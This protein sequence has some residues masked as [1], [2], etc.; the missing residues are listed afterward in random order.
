DETN[1]V[2]EDA[3]LTVT[4]GS[5]DVLHGDTDVDSGD[6]LTATTYSHTS[7]TNQSGGSASSANGNSGTAGTNAVVGYYGTL[8]LAADGTYTYAADQSAADDLDASDTA[9]D[10][11]TY[12]VSDGTAT[13][14]ATITITVTG[15]NDAP[16]A[17]NDTDAVNEDATVTRTSGDSLLMADDSDADD[18][19]SFTV[20][21]IAVTG[22]SN[23]AVTASSTYNSGSPETVTGTYGTL[24]VGAN[25]TYT[26]VADQSA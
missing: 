4:D 14:T 13:D 10:V 16:A 22:G 25:G 2:N 5:S 23:N 15:V 9:T 12:T 21:Q 17:V 19:D 18:D 20:T 11:F 26:Y 1:S 3:T 6:T 8:T 7:A 24:T